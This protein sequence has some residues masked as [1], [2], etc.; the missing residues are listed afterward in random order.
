MFKLIFLRSK[1]IDV[2]NTIFLASKQTV[3]KFAGTNIFPKN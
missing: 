1:Q 2:N 3:E